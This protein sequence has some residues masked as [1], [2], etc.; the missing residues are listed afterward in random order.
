M[1]RRTPS[2]EY[3]DG[4]LGTITSRQSD[5]LLDSLKGRQNQRSYQRGV[6]KGE[7]IDPGDYYWPDRFTPDMQ[8]R[9]E[10]QAAQIDT[11]TFLVEKHVPVG[12][13]APKLNPERVFDPH[14]MGY[15]EQTT[16]MQRQMQLRRL[17]PSWRF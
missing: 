4:Y 5:K 10:A 7:R 16:G 3:P 8:L 2:A 17:A 11:S 6:H 1:F 14:A 13:M 9:Q 15:V 12:V